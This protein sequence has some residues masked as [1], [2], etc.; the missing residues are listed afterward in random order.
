[1][2][3][4]V[5]V[6]AEF[7]V[8]KPAGDDHGGWAFSSGYKGAQSISEVTLVLG[9][10]SMALVQGLQPVAWGKDSTVGNKGQIA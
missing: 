5:G 2:S 6:F 7:G 9:F 10:V 3:T 4:A 1:M 8:W